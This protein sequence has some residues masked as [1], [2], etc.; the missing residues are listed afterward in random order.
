MGKQ[1]EP[2]A[3]KASIVYNQLNTIT[4]KMLYSKVY[5]EASIVQIKE[6]LKLLKVF[7][8]PIFSEQGLKIT[9]IEEI[10]G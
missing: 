5:D 8:E 7:L 9:T 10:N 2:Y 4:D 3:L 1:L 6:R